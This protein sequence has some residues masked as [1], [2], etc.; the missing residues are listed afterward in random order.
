MMRVA[1]MHAQVQPQWRPLQRLLW[2]APYQQPHT[3]P[4]SLNCWA[5][6]RR[7]R[8]MTQQVHG[9][10]VWGASSWHQPP[11]RTVRTGRA[12]ATAAA[13]RPRPQ[14]FSTSLHGLGH[15]LGALTWELVYAG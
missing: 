4:P 15:R 12:G 9:P 5:V 13:S 14:V 10:H 7:Q 2:P 1:F 3:H 8:N 11:G 6:S